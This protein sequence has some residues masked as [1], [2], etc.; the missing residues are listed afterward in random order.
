MRK[1]ASQT[2]IGPDGYQ[3][4]FGLSDYLRLGYVPPEPGGWGSA[5]TT[6]EYTLDDF[7]IAQLARAAGE[8]AVYR[9]YMQRS[10][11]WRKLFNPFTGFIEARL[12][13]GTWPVPFNPASMDGFVEGNAWQYTW[14]VPYDLRDLFHVIGGAGRATARL[15]AFFR[16]LN[17]GPLSPHYWAGNEPGLEVPWEYDFAGRPWRTQA[18][19]RRIETSLYAPAPAG[20]PGN[21]DLGTL[22]AW[23]VWAAI[24]LYPEIPGV[25]GLVVG[26]PLFPH[27]VV[28]AGRR[29]LTIDA[30]AAAPTRPYVHALSL[31]GRPYNRSWL[32]LRA[33]GQRSVMR[34]TLASKPDRSWGAKPSEGPPSFAP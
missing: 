19:V 6:L 22:S 27:I 17:A 28:R 9:R 4:R 8:R 10:E 25:P 33:I 12:A 7:S 32:P 20:L 21:D 2:G 14:M 23:Y 24:G 18:V 31:N 16:R 15:D 11:G 30:P 1:G 26:S 3:E 5:A 34:F 13:G 29:S